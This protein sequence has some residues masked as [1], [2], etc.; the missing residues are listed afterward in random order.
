MSWITL[1]RENSLVSWLAFEVWNLSENLNIPLGRFAPMVF[2]LMIGR[3]P[4]RA[5][6]DETE[7]NK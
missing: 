1:M 2:G 5:R 6:M 3:T 4:H 7:G